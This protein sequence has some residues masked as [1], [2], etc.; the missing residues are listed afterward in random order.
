MRQECLEIHDKSL[1][2]LFFKFFFEDLSPFG[3]TTDIPV[4]DFGDISSGFQS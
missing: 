2:F 3:G 4:W 1:N